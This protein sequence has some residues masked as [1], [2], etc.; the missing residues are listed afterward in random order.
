MIQPPLMQSPRVSSQPRGA[1]SRPSGPRRPLQ[2]P[3]RPEPSKRPSPLFALVLLVLLVGILGGWGWRAIA[4]L[5]WIAGHL[6]TVAYN[7]AYDPVNALT[8]MNTEAAS[9]SLKNTTN[10][11]S[12]DSTNY[13]S[14]PYANSDS[15]AAPSASEQSSSQTDT[16]NAEDTG[17]RLTI[18]AL[19]LNAPVENVGMLTSGALA[20]PQLHRWDGAGLYGQGAAPGGIGSAVIDGY[21]SRPDG[22]PALFAHLNA[23][24]VGDEITLLSQDNTIMHF[25]VLS[26]QSYLPDQAPI[27][28]IFG[29]SSGSYLN[30]ISTN[31]TKTS[32][33]GLQTIV[34]T[35][36]DDSSQ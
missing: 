33:P 7:R 6:P 13:T 9:L 20:L 27:S 19:A 23:L 10:Q 11:P 17:L 1:R 5:P 18:P 3:P 25:H 36:F 26:V 12:S 21:Q 15:L 30:L 29:D 4:R 24:H 28:S 16:G 35:V 22:K 14:S 2:R 31:A 32:A 8:I 34:H